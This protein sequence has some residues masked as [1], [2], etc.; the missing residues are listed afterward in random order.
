MLRERVQQATDIRLDKV[1]RICRE[2]ASG[3]YRTDSNA[4]ADR[5]L[6]AMRNDREDPV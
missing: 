3:N 6:A 5:I 4:I 2:I 1:E